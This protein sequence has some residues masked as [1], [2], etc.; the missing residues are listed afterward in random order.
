MDTPGAEAR[1]VASRERPKAE[2]LGYLES[3]TTTRSN[4][5]SKDNTGTL[6]YAQDDDEE[7]TTTTANARTS[8]GAKARTTPAANART[9]ATAKAGPPALRKDDKLRTTIPT[10]WVRK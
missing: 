8:A 10:E 3:K 9:T 1:F 5:K 2:A 4:G 7:E 6:R